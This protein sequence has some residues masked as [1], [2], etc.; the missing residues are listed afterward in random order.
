VSNGLIVTTDNQETKLYSEAIV[1]RPGRNFAKGIT[2]SNLGKPDFEKALEQ[3]AAYCDALE[4]C[5]VELIVLEA[6]E[7]YP[8]G[9]FVEDTAIVNSKVAIISNPGAVSRRG[10]EVEISRVLSGYR[11]SETIEF[12]GTLEGG[13]ILRVENHYYIGLSGRTNK[14][15]ADQLSGILSKYGFTSSEIKV[16]AGLHLKSDIAYLGKGNFI[17]TPAFSKMVYPANTIIL[18]QDESYSAN[19]LLV[20][21]FLLIPKGFP[22]SKTKIADLGYNIIE[23]EMSEFRKMDGGLTCLSLLF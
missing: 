13:D 21:D 14:E 3:H 5:G 17:S 9:C 1:R 23:L 8:D 22:K 4:R 19:C 6:D 11:K 2:T 16:E 10:E 12:P 20:N 15:G 7:R 18:D